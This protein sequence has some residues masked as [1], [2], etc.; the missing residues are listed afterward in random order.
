MAKREL[1]AAE[2]LVNFTKRVQTDAPVPEAFNRNR[3]IQQCLATHPRQ[4]D[5]GLCKHVLLFCPRCTRC[6]WQVQLREK[7]AVLIC[8]A[9]RYVRI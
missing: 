1:E 6:S 4:T 3:V 5:G 9:C 7:C 2:A 8:T